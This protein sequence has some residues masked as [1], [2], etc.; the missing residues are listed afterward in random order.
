MSTSDARVRRPAD[1]DQMLNELKQLGIFPDYADAL[2][3]A[4]ALGFR[5]GYRKPFTNTSE[6]IRVEVFNGRFDQTIMRL[7]AIKETGDPMIMGELQVAER[8]RCFEEYANGGL[9]TMKRE[10]LDTKLDW[11]EGLLALVQQEED[12][13][14]ILDDITKLADD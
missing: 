5:K 13:N 7:I 4:A 1:F 14:P 10:I 11:R 12:E 2:V 3:F 8:M 9:D 6:R